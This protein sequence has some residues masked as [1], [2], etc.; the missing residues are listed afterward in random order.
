MQTMY[1]NG[2]EVE[3]SGEP[4]IGDNRWGAYVSIFAPSENPMH[5]KNVYPKTRMAEGR[6]FCSKEAA[7]AEAKKEGSTLLESL[8]SPGGSLHRGPGALWPEE[9]VLLP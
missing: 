6:I 8:R 5:L 9:P 1:I 4:L 2:Y 7:L 3:V